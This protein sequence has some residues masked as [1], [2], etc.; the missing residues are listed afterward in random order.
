MKI[1]SLILGLLLFSACSI[2]QSSENTEEKVPEEEKLDEVYIFDDDDDFYEEPQT[3]TEEIK[4]LENEI[5]NTLNSG[6]NEGQ[7]NQT[8]PVVNEE[9][10]PQEDLDDEPVYYF[11][12]LG[13]FS[14]L[15]LAEQFVTQISSQTPF[16]LSIIYNS[17]TS[18]YNVRSSAF[19][20]RE[21]VE[22]IRRDLWSK[23]LFNDAFIVTE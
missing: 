9:N 20:T 3:N 4:Q 15:K 16:N 5:D 6:N 21:E 12:Q 2:F 23:N 1:L 17:K 19:S 14:K 10:A 22:Q 13:A 8:Q 11:L 7:Q 18:Y